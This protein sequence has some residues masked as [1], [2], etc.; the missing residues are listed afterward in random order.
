MNSLGHKKFWL[1]TGL[2][3]IGSVMIL[4][5]VPQVPALLERI[6]CY[7]SSSL[8]C[9]VMRTDQFFHMS[10]YF[11][12]MMWFGQLF[13]RRVYPFCAAG[14]ILISGLVELGQGLFT[15]CRQCEMGDLLANTMGVLVAWLLLE[16]SISHFLMRLER[17]VQNRTSVSLPRISG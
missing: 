14:F 3:A 6:S 12:L 16:T 2:A 9:T 8:P 5:F 13:P 7:L 4:S 17:W 15:T 10:A 1:F 11:G